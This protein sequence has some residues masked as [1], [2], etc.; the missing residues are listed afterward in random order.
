M[1]KIVLCLFVFCVILIG[2]ILGDISLFDFDYDESGIRVVMDESE[3]VDGVVNGSK[4]IVY[5]DDLDALKKIPFDGVTIECPTSK[6]KSFIKIFDIKI[7]NEYMINEV[8]VLDCKSRLM[9]GDTN[10][11]IAIGERML[12]GFPLILDSF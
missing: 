11:Q 6:F 8:R 5:F 7:T 2:L 12:I 4:E 1:K 10:F 9:P 3:S